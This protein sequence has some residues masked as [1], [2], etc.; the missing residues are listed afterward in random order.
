MPLLLGGG[1]GKK[2]F[3]L[4]QSLEVAE[5]LD[6]CYAENLI[7]LLTSLSDIVLFSAAIPYQGGT[8]HINCQP[9][10]Y[11]AKIFAQ[12][13]FLCFD[14]LRE[15]IWDKEAIAPWY[16]QNSFIFIHKN[17]KECFQQIQPTPNPLYL[18]HPSIWKGCMEHTKYL[19]KQIEH[20]SQK[21]RNKYNKTLAKRIEFAFKS[22]KSK[23]KATL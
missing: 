17:R 23:L 20:E 18:V 12:H 1:G 4:A 7:A 5:H 10:S 19:E 13:N 16:R 2:P 9:P 3:E 6:E 15:K 8:H 11:W 14:I 22:I 21:W